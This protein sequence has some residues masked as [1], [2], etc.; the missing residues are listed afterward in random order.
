MRAKKWFSK[1]LKKMLSI[2]VIVNLI[3]PSFMPLVSYAIENEST[4]VEVL[5]ETSISKHIPYSYGE[6]RG[7]ILQQ[8]VSSTLIYP[9]GM[10]ELPIANNAT[11]IDVIEY[12]GIEPERIEVIN[13]ENI[14]YSWNT[15]TSKLVVNS[16]KE[17]FVTY[18][19][20]QNAYD[21]NQNIIPE[22]E[23][24]IPN[25]Q[26]PI[27]TTVNCIY[28]LQ[29]NEHEE[30]IMG[31]QQI[32]VGL[33]WQYG[34]LVTTNEYISNKK[35]SK[36]K[37]YANAINGEG[38][39]SINVNIRDEI[40]ISKIDAIKQIEIYDSSFKYTGDLQ[41]EQGE[42]YSEI[43]TDELSVESSTIKSIFQKANLEKTFGQ[44]Y[45]IQIYDGEELKE[46]ITEQTIEN[47]DGNIVIQYEN[48]ISN[49][50]IVTSAPANSNVLYI[51]NVKALLP[52]E[53]LDI[54]R[55]QKLLHVRTNG[56]AKL[57]MQDDTYSDIYRESVEEFEESITKV[58]GNISETTLNSVLDNEEIE[59]RLNLNN[60]I[61]KSDLW[62][63]GMIL[64][65]LPEEIERVDIT[66]TQLLYQDTMENIESKLIEYNGHS[67]IQISLIGEQKHYISDT[68]EKGTYIILTLNLGLKELTP[69]KENN[70]IKVY[71]YNE[72]VR[73]YESE[74]RVSV[75]LE[76]K[77]YECGTTIINVNY[78]SPE[79]VYNVQR[80][81]G[82]NGDKAITSS[83]EEIK[84]GT[85]GIREEQ[86][87]V[88]VKNILLNN[89]R[90]EI[91]N[92]KVLGQL[93]F[94][95]N[96]DL[97]SNI[98]FGSTINTKL[99]ELI[100][101][102]EKISHIYYT[103][104]QIPSINSGNWTET[105]ET[106]EDVKAFLIEIDRLD[107]SEKIEFSY[108]VI[109]PE[110]LDHCEYMYFENI[111]YYSD[112]EAS[113][114]KA[115]TAKLGLTTGEGAVFELTQSVSVG[116]GNNVN[117]E[118]L[119]RYEVNIKNIGHIDAE[120]VI[121]R[122]VVPNW[123]SYKEE[124]IVQAATSIHTQYNYY[125]SNNTMEWNIG[126]LKSGE[127]I[128]LEFYVESNRIPTLIEYYSGNPNFTKEG[129]KYYLIEGEERIEI[130]EVPE[131]IIESNTSISSD[132]L[133]K[134]IVS[135][136]T[137]NPIIRG[138]ITINEEASVDKNVYLNEEE[139]LNYSI[140][141]ENIEKT[142]SVKDIKLSK[143]LPE[144]LTYISANLLDRNETIQYNEETREVWTIIDSLEAGKTATLQI[145]TK[146]NQ[147]EE[148]AYKKE[149]KT[150]TKAI[151]NEK[152]ISSNEI[153]NYIAKPKIT[154]KVSYDITQR[155]IYEEDIINIVITAT[156]EKDQTAGNLKIS[157]IIN[158]DFKFVSGTME[159]GELKTTLTYDG[160]K[161]IYATA[162][163]KKGETIRINLKIRA[164]DLDKGILEKEVAIS[165]FIEAIN[166]PKRE[167][168]NKTYLIEK[169]AKNK[170]K[171]AKESGQIDDIDKD[172]NITYKIQGHAWLDEDR[173]GA[174]NGIET[175]LSNI[176]VYL[177][178]DGVLVDKGITNEKGIYEF[179][180]LSSGKYLVV[181]DYNTEIYEPTV[182]QKN[183][184]LPDNNSDVISSIVNINGEKKQRAITNEINI[185]NRNI[186]NIDLGLT[187]IQNFDLQ[188][189]SNVSKIVLRTKNGIKTYEYNDSKLTKLEIKSKEIDGAIALIEY[190]IKVSNIG[191]I[192][193]IASQIMSYKNKDLSFNS[194]FNSN[195]YE[196][197]DGNYYTNELENTI[198]KP[199]ETKEIKIILVKNLTGNKTGVI[200]NKFEISKTYN[201]KGL[202]DKDKTNN[203]ITVQCLLSI[204]TGLENMYTLTIALIVI[205]TIS[206]LGIIIVIKS[207]GKEKAILIK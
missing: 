11:I 176:Q 185:T 195:W 177:L 116:D 13:G 180:K 16:A 201:S 28:I 78:S 121:A 157:Q 59:L 175:A 79:T 152:E 65:E 27:S 156:N 162:N 32:N 110:N 33:L 173:D 64:I 167:I 163:L 39:Y 112:T 10:E 25:E 120:N 172:G 88:T 63:N 199:G 168:S 145:K 111:M 31:S 35:I 102:S 124:Q 148:N 42:M 128:K 193:G 186:Y 46:T 134:E 75:V 62:K 192:D 71:F 43:E 50:K 96:K 174:R 81:S 14:E 53:E 49:L 114:K 26:I 8:K 127:S 77:E 47:S 189:T 203:N 69:N 38:I 66:N 141:I 150:Y 45:T 135:N 171:E 183:E 165:T 40:E 198:I 103:S 12:A 37:L 206:L 67:A 105:P 154:T 169:T 7:V 196:A 140:T 90:N 70:E 101:I 143:I 136:T 2:A 41:A 58:D 60:S 61:E 108:N 147:L 200:E 73:D 18:Y 29:N 22:D 109:V 160:Q 68:I 149:I 204:A 20:G 24:N 164:S 133:A 89:T 4:N 130:S 181:F 99:K 15:E 178:K 6:E 57:V 86:K 142:A 158:K 119:L 118:Q 9:E 76:E 1:L 100:P 94:K 23:E 132:N 3:S 205:I 83:I 104:D 166:V 170:L 125:S 113:N 126:E 144:G 182:Y 155:N 139:D 153:I 202:Q 188:L 48:P 54:E 98:E 92:I 82:Y 72:N 107:I 44:E 55:I 91:T 84:L 21:A 80:I 151:L 179:K 5:I 161:E 122:S 187:K 97:D 129:D 159:I 137:R 74:E 131:I 34:N 52:N 19:Y 146:T 115:N 56:E 85:V 36:G 117:E 184:V 197:S 191:D 30:T 194:E 123:T 207:K 106:L 87:D 190:T 51:E 17:F 93:S 95:N 138:Q